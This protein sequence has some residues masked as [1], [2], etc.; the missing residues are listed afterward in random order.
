MADVRE[1]ITVSNWASYRDRIVPIQKLNLLVIIPDHFQPQAISPQLRYMRLLESFSWVDYL[2]RAPNIN[3]RRRLIIYHWRSDKDAPVDIQHPFLAFLKLSRDGEF[4][5]FWS[6]VVALFVALWVT[7]TGYP[8]LPASKVAA[9][10]VVEILLGHE[11]VSGLAATGMLGFVIGLIAKWKVSL[12]TL[13]WADK[14]MHGIEGLLARPK[15]RQRFS[16]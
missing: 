2:D 1:G 14:L 13:R 3:R 16:G 12:A 11:I 9:A 5:R 4:A 8:L 10:K 15:R 7:E 6:I